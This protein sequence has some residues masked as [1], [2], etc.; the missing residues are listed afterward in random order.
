MPSIEYPLAKDIAENEQQKEDMLKLIIE[1][2]IQLKKM[3]ERVEELLKEKEA[4]QLV[5]VPI[6]VP[7]TFASTELSSS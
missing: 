6:I 4:T 5:R 3:E 1:Q 2:N 7:T